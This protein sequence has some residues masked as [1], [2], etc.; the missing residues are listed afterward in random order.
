MNSPAYIHNERVTT[1]ADIDIN[2]LQSLLA[3]YGLHINMIEPGQPIPGSYW[4]E[5]EAGIIG[6]Q[7]YVY[8]ATP[9]HSILHESCHYVCMD[10]YRRAQLHTDTG[11]DYLEENAVCYLQILLADHIPAY[12][13]E[14]MFS[15]MNLWG[16]SFRL[17][18][19]KAWFEQDAEDALTW[20]LEHKL[21]NE[22]QQPTWVLRQH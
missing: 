10:N 6:D 7:L 13:K 15:D 5:P 19:A 1:L 4:G 16:Y 8:M 20:L 17:G 21:I 9:V 22:T 11:G 14:T 2:A 18:C 12:S 3:R